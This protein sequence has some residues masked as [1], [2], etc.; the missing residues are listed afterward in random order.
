MEM[1]LAKFILNNPKMKRKHILRQAK[2]IME[3]LN[4]PGRDQFNFSKGWYERFRERMSKQ[5]IISSVKFEEL[6]KMEVKEEN[7]SED[8]KHEYLSEGEDISD[9]SEDDELRSEELIKF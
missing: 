8:I 7:I 5:K 9:D 3:D 1:R 2:Q 4:I 6:V